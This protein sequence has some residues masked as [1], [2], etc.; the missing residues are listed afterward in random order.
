MISRCT[1]SIP[2]EDVVLPRLLYC[3]LRC[4]QNWRWHSQNW[5]WRS[6]TCRWRSQDCHRRPHACRQRSQVLPGAPKVLSGAPR[7]SQ[8][9]HNFSHGTPVPVIRYPSYFEGQPELVLA[10]GPSNLP[11]ATGKTV[12]FGSRTVQK[13]DPLLVGGPNPAPYQSTRGFRQVWL[14]LLGPISGFPLQ[15]VLFMV[16][17]RFP[18]VNHKILTMVR[19]CSFWMYWPPLWSKYVDKRSLTHPGNERQCSVNDFRSCILNNQSGHWLQIVI[20]EVLASF[21]CK[22]RSNTLPAPSWK[23]ASTI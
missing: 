22:N 2:K 14:D 12:W 5:R 11:A 16:A 9:Y 18:T 8:T 21:I 10:T 15:V 4:S 7:C 1:S 20:T 6:Q 3:D 23:W 13:S 19:P 17:F